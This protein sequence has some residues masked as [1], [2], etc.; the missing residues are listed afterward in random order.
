MKNEL[1]GNKPKFPSS[2]ISDKVTN[3]FSEELS[4]KFSQKYI[5]VIKNLKSEHDKDIFILG[6]MTVLNSL[7]KLE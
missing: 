2:I 4:T 7:Y 1:R 3:P 5:D 6:L